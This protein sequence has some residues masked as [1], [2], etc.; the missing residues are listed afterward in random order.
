VLLQTTTTV[1]QTVAELCHAAPY[2]PCSA[3]ECYA[4]PAQTRSEPLRMQ[5]WPSANCHCDL[6]CLHSIVRCATAT[7]AIQ[8]QECRMLP[9]LAPTP[10]DAKIAAMNCQCKTA[11]WSVLLAAQPAY[12]TKRS[13]HR[14]PCFCFLTNPSVHQKLHNLASEQ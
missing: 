6:Q 3:A 1:L 7:V 5:P 9:N 4:C 14:I 8:L 12:L 13:K 10:A 2:N 11:N